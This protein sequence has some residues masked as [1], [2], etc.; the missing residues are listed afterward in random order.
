M[1]L[2]AM[3][4]IGEHW[5][6]PQTRPLLIT[7]HSIADRLGITLERAYGISHCLGRFYYG[8]SHTHI[9][10]LRWRLDQLEELIE[11]G[12]NLSEAADLMHHD[13]ADS[14]TLPRR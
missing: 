12:M 4:R 2:V 3:M 9:R 5:E 8:P 10:V 7:V 13:G 6:A 11:S 1:E 14:L